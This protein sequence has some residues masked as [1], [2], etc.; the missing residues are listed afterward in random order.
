MR[1]MSETGDDSIFAERR[2]P[3]ESGHVGDSVFH[4]LIRCQQQLCDVWICV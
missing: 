1:K 2:H 3:Y 4:V